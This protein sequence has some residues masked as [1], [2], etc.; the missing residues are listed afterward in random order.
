[1]ARKFLT[2]RDVAGQLNI[3]IS[4]VYAMVKNGDIPHTKVNSRIRFNKAVFNKWLKLKQ[5][6]PVQ[7][8]K[9][10]EPSAEVSTV[11]FSSPHG[12]TFMWIVRELEKK[13]GIEPYL[14]SV[15]LN[16]TK[17]MIR[18]VHYNVLEGQELAELKKK[19]GVL[20]KVN[21]LT[22]VYPKGLH[23]ILVART[24]ATASSR[25][26]FA[27]ICQE[28][29]KRCYE[30][31]LPFPEEW[32]DIPEAGP[33]SVKEQAPKDE[34]VSRPEKKIRAVREP[35]KINRIPKN[36][37]EAKEVDHLKFALKEYGDEIP[38][39]AGLLLI[40]GI[41]ERITGLDLSRFSK[42]VSYN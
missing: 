1:M 7:E 26:L 20:K 8:L 17:N 33:L 6:Q 23:H 37:S 13:L 35:F 36:K 29:E 27:T 12:P 21:R 16:H 5:T 2:V 25:Q 19:C 34:L 18:G 41:C 40:V 11:Y 32:T 38:I 31:S 22:V 39:T 24:W 4:T 3:S 10:V 42:S 28:V 15:H 30:E 9:V 14:F